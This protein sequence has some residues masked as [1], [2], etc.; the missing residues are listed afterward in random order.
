MRNAVKTGVQL[1][2]AGAAAGGV[3]LAGSGVAQADP[4]NPW[5]PGVPN[6]NGPGVNIG[7]PGNPLPP[8]QVNKWIDDLIPNF[9]GKGKW[10]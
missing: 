7:I 9:N 8:G 1:L 4:W 10:R 2:L 5:I 6:I 3:L